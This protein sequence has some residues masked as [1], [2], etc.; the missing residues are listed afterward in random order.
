MAETKTVVKDIRQMMI[1]RNKNRRKV[2]AYYIGD[3]DKKKHLD[4]TV[5]D[6]DSPR[7]GTYTLD[8]YN[9]SQEFS[10]NNNNRLSNRTIPKIIL[11]EF[12]P[13]K[14][15]NFD[16]ITKAM[17]GAAADAVKSDGQKKGFL[18]KIVDAGK[19][20]LV[21]AGV[22]AGYRYA[23]DQAAD[24]SQNNATNGIAMKFVRSLMTGQYLNVF[25][26]PF[27]GEDYL[28]ADS[29]DGWSEG[30]AATLLGKEA[31]QTLKENFNINFPMAPQWTKGT[32]K[33]VDWK[34]TFHLINDTTE[35]ALRNFKFLNALTSGNY[36][37]QLGFLQQSPNVY[38]VYCP[39]RFHQYFSALGVKVTRKGKERENLEL[40]RILGELGYNGFV[41]SENAI[42][43]P[44]AY[45]IEIHC[46]DLTPN[47]FNTYIDHMVGH[48]KVKIG[49]KKDRIMSVSL[50]GFLTSGKGE[51]K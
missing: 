35:N 6:P 33:K 9:W 39:G 19:K 47:N 24:P 42:L 12:Q 48:E 17:A 32:T 37:M 30:S 45:E 46:T 31:A 7:S 34:N 11:T 21:K 49:D 26:I 15:F 40:S 8:D 16:E 1:F 38:D 4:L 29:V 14:S 44:D 28:V 36:W 23:F 27:F 18:G 10:M 25:E 51:I 41:S 43:F 3:V 5:A 13:E 50:G 2:D 20:N 22:T